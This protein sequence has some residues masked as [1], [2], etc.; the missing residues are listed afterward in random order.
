MG[1]V[2]IKQVLALYKTLQNYYSQGYLSSEC[3]STVNYKFK[4]T[5]EDATKYKT[6]KQVAVV[7]KYH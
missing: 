5:I 7:D 1:S 2:S 6:R 3:F 4:F